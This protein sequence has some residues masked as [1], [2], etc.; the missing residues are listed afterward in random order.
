MEK[1]SSGDNTEDNEVA[2]VATNKKESE[3]GGEKKPTNPDAEKTCNHCK[4]KGH[5]EVN[6]WK[7]FPDKIPDKVKAVRKKQEEKQAAAAA[8]VETDG[9]GNLLMT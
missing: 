3:K 2:L 7:K 8:A 1:G 6:C 9:D 5:V 4:K